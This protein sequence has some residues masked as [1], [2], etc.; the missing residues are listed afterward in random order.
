MRWLRWAL[1]VQPFPVVYRSLLS[2]H[3][4]RTP[5]SYSWHPP[6]CGC[7]MS[8]MPSLTSPCP[9]I[10]DVARCPLC[11]IDHPDH[12]LMRAQHWSVLLVEYSDYVCP[13]SCQLQ[14][15][16]S[17]SH[18]SFCLISANHGSCLHTLSIII[19]RRPL[20]LGFTCLRTAPRG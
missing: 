4:L 18:E 8:C 10:R 2:S 17:N 13:I 7:G 14:L 20:S 6:Y 15:Y 19:R 12:F 16:T 5:V 1:V 3:S 11:D 9:I